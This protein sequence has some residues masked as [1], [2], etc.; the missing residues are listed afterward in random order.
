MGLR[1]GGKYDVRMGCFAGD[2]W[3][4]GALAGS[5]LQEFLVHHVFSLVVVQC[6]PVL[7]APDNS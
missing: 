3:S 7:N 4:M 5:G 1:N 6:G 2:S